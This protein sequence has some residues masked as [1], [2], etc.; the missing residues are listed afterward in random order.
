MNETM[1]TTTSD[2]S[3]ARDYTGYL[4]G[5]HWL[6]GHQLM[7]MVRGLPVEGINWDVRN[8]PQPWGGLW[9]Q[10]KA[11]M[12]ASKVHRVN[13]SPPAPGREDF[14]NLDADWW[15][16]DMSRC[17]ILREP[18]FAKFRAVFV[19]WR[20]ANARPKKRQATDEEIQTWLAGWLAERYAETGRAVKRDDACKATVAEFKGV[21]TPTVRRMWKIVDKPWG[22]GRPPR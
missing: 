10:F 21:D 19:Q 18:Q 15:L 1:P 4:R 6:R 8:P 12:L 20:Q 2:C 9:Q 13:S 17:P 11:S 22:R 16:D 3:L 7:N 14:P 5:R